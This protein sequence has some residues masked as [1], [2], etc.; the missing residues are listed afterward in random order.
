MFWMKKK[1][2]TLDQANN[3]YIKSLENLVNAQKSQIDAL[4]HLVS[5]LEEGVELRE[6]QI[7]SLKPSIETYRELAE[8]G[9]KLN[10]EQLSINAFNEETIVY[11]RGQLAIAQNKLMKV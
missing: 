9:I 2:L 8:R 1:K 5:V 11:L 4:N 3:N 7:N 10:E 6:Q